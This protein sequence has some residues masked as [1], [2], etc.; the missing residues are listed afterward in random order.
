MFGKRIKLS[1]IIKNMYDVA[2]VENSYN[3][4]FYKLLAF[5]LGIFKYGNL[6]DSLPQR[7]IE[8]NLLLTNHCVIFEKNGELL[9]NPTTLFKQERNVYL[10]PTNA[11]YANPKIKSETLKLGIDS[12]II[13]NNRLQDNL[14]YLPSDGGLLTFIQRYSR[15]LADIESTINNYIVNARIVSYPVAS[16]DK[17]GA[18]LD[19]FFEKIAL[20]KRAYITDNAII[21]NFRNVDIGKFSIK[22]GVNDLLIARDKILEQFFRD[23]GVRMY[24]PKKAQV[25]TEEIESNDDLLLISTKDMLDERKKGIERVNAHWGTNITIEIAEG[26]KNDSSALKTENNEGV[27]SYAN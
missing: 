1:E 20:G 4:W 5:C 2:D 8:L 16:N 18:S 21:E 3:Y 25:N 10:Y 14:Y 22:D 27:T 15:Q 6:P 11:I 24:N 23:I 19:K 9:T 12:E 26:F 17:I 13:Y 7:E